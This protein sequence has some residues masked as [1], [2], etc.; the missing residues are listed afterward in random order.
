MRNIALGFGQ[1]KKI[2]DCYQKYLFIGFL[3]KKKQ[4]QRKKRDPLIRKREEQAL[5]EH[6]LAPQQNIHRP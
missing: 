1:F 6:T 2:R 4:K 3:L 5:V